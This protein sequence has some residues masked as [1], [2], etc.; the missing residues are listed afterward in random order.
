MPDLKR[1]TKTIKYQREF[2]GINTATISNTISKLSTILSPFV[3]RTAFVEVLYILYILAI[4]NE[5]YVW[6]NVY[7]L[8]NLT[9]VK[10]SSTEF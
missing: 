7:F 8:H 4:L 6:V 3:R 9:T 2:E 10:C 1:F 5:I